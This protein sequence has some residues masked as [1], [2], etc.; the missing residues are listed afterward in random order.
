MSREDIPQGSNSEIRFPELQ[1]LRDSGRHTIDLGH[2]VFTEGQKVDLEAHC[3]YYAGRVYVV[4][5][6]KAGS[7]SPGLKY[8]EMNVRYFTYPG[9]IMVWDISDRYV[10]PLAR[11]KENGISLKLLD[12]A[13]QAVRTVARLN[14]MNPEA[15]VP[16]RIEMSAEQ[17]SVWRFARDGGYELVTDTAEQ[18]E[19]LVLQEEYMKAYVANARNLSFFARE[20]NPTDF[21]LVRLKM[22]DGIAR[23]LAV[24]HKPTFDAWLK[25]HKLKREREVGD[26][27]ESFNLHWEEIMRTE[28][29]RK[30]SSSLLLPFFVRVVYAKDLA[31]T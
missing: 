12:C 10:N 23:D 26:E 19:M 1:S 11:G 8:A 14:K 13:E 20:D 7:H 6:E 24:V 4:V 5:R 16:A 31:S 18:K 9:G 30:G 2:F 28:G 21:M 27:F 29:Q 17:P 3:E 22:G 15:R 25:D